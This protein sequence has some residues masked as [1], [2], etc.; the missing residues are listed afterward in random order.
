MP[1]KL[2]REH[3]VAISMKRLDETRLADQEGAVSAWT[4]PIWNIGKLNLN[5]RVYTED[6]A[7]RLVAE[8]KAT[9]AYDSHNHDYGNA[10]NEVV[11]VAKNPRIEGDQLWVDIYMVDESYST[12]VEA[13]HKA[14]VGIG[15]SSVG[16][17]ETDK[18]GV[19][20]AKTYELLRYLDFVVDPANETHAVPGKNGKENDSVQDHESDKV[21][22]EG[23]KEPSEEIKERI[24][25]HKR[26]EALD[27]K[28]KTDE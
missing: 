9:I 5:G 25:I 19:V 13:I 11:A 6:L 23:S 15:V 28:E 8:N 4:A 22:P 24:E 20:N 16:Y 12:K 27:N 21:L 18:D 7:K 10:Y 2:L 14:G 3:S 17:G 26:L 1:K